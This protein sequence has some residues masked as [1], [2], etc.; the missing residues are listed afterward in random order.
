MNYFERSKDELLAELEVLKGTYGSYLTRH[1]VLDLSRGKPDSV[2]LDATQQ[3]LD[4][5]LSRDLVVSDGVDYRNYG[6]L[7]GIPAMKRFFSE[8]FSIDEKKIFVGGNSSLQL[9]YDTLMLG[10]PLDV[11]HEKAGKVIEI[12]EAVH[13]QNPLPVKY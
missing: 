12:I 10:K 7:D 9:M 5:P 2:Q 6:M 1:L 13:A 3:M 4:I 8:L 11:T